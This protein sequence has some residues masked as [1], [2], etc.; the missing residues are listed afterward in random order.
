LRVHHAKV[1]T[2]WLEGKTGRIELAFLL[3]DAPE[4]NPDESLNRYFKTA[5]RTGPV[6]CDKQSLLD[7]AMALQSLTA[8]PQTVCAYFR[9]PAATY[10]CAGIFGPD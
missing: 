7:K 5:L 10:A 9:R 3:P 6:S 1:V 2:T 4:V 8:M